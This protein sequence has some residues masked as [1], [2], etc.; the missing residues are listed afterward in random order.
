MIST[1]LIEASAGTG[2][3]YTMASL[4]IR[5]LLQAGENHFSRPLTVEEILV[6]TFT[7]AATQE[8]KE[9]IR[10][11]IR[12]SK[13]QL[14]S[15]LETH[16]KQVFVDN[17]F[18]A[19]LV[20][21]LPD[22]NIAIQRLRLA[23]Q[24]MD[25]AAIYTI[26]G[27]CRRVLMQYAFHSG[28]HF[29]MDLVKDETLL[30]QGFVQEFWR[31]QFYSAPFAVA[32]FIH[33]RFQSPKN[34]LKMI[35]AYVSGDNL[36]VQGS[37]PPSLTQIFQQ[38]E[39][40][41]ARIRQ[42][43]ATWQESAVEIQQV[44]EKALKNKQL[45][46]ASFRSNHLTAR[47]DKINQWAARADQLELPDVLTTYFSQQRLNSE[48]LLENAEP[49]EHAIF[50]Q[51][52]ELQNSDDHYLQ[53]SILYHYMQGVNQKLTA[54]KL[55]HREKSFDDLLRLL[56][57]ALLSAQ[58]DD[59]AQRLRQQY[60]FAMIDEFQDTDNRQYQIFA[61]IYLKQENCGFIMIGDPKQAI[62]KFRGADIFTYLHAAQQAER[63][64]LDK[65]YRSSAP[66]IE[67]ANQF[68]DFPKSP[69]L[70]DEIAFQPVGVGRSQAQ[71][72]FNNQAQAP[73]Q[74]YLGD[75]LKAAQSESKQLFADTCAYSI[76]QWLG[77]ADSKTTESKTAV[78][79]NAEK[80]TALFVKGEHSE[81][82]KANDIA[83]L[84]ENWYEA[85]LV[86]DSLRKQ[87][88]AS[89]YLSDRSNVFESDE[90]KELARILA[91]CLNPSNTKAIL[92][93]IATSLFAL[94]S[95]D[96]QQIKREDSLLEQWVNRFERY[97]RSW[98]HQGV[99]AMLYSLFLE[100]TDGKCSMVEKVRATPTGERRLTNLL[101]LAE[102]LQQ[103]SPL[104]ETEASLLRW[105]ELQIQH[106]Q[107]G[108]DEQQLR[109]ES[110]NQL[111]KIVT[112]HK[113]KGL[114]YGLVWLPFIAF[115]SL[116]KAKNIN[117]YHDENHQE[118]WDIRQQQQALSDKESM[119]EK[120]RLLY[121]ALTRAK[122]Q[123]NVA[124]PTVLA[125]EWTAIWYAL[126]QGKIGTNPK[127]KESDDTAQLLAQFQNALTSAEI[128][129]QLIS[130]L[131]L[132]QITQK[133]PATT[134]KT[135]LQAAVFTGDIELNWQL[136]SFTGLIQ[137]H[138]QHQKQNR[139]K[140]AVENSTVLDLAKDNDQF[141]PMA[142][143][144]NSEKNVV[145]QWQNYP[146]N[147]SPVD[148]PQGAKV[149]T[150][151]HSVLEKMNFN[152]PVNQDV[153]E[154]ICQQNQL[155]ESWFEPVAQWFD[156]ILH[157]PLLTDTPLCFADLAPQN[158]LKEMQFYFNL[159]RSFK[160]D[161]FNQI[162]QQH[163]HLAGEALLFDDVQG[164]MRGFIDLVFRHQG[165]YYIVDY[166][167]NFLGKLPQDYQ[168]EQLVKAMKTHHYD[169]QYLLYTLALNR[170]LKQRDPQYQYESHFG[171]VIY[172]FLRGMQGC[173]ASNE[174]VSGV[175][176]DRPEALLIEKLEA[177]FNA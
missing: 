36:K 21:Y 60:P 24:N 7:E 114:E 41:V 148:F 153:I 127:V 43:K 77:G 140:S 49:V 159:H 30:L 93:A 165:K 158:C 176:F 20:D 45:K 74:F 90:A 174:N 112:I 108:A 46:A 55:T 113:S 8:L 53:N 104:N 142:L 67:V 167:S 79:K 56:R 86:Q 128:N 115:S 70:Y 1:T 166:K 98:F 9:R 19:E 33:H 137:T 28:I 54:Y 152:Q 13:Q 15:Y 39:D 5:L 6:V 57:D 66:L 25:L 163:H 35:R 78:Q 48:Y 22:L 29:E 156:A 92:N 164:M 168:Q 136:S 150:L 100:K 95:A 146:E 125:K 117:T 149:G 97:Q 131:N 109:L 26:H 63:F 96:I 89:V 111:V 47:F 99:L 162:L 52:D 129:T 88:I 175:F 141:L 31:E 18:L 145:T 34:V 135:A 82:V 73:I 11:R 160:V 10:Q 147:R 94:S 122:Y 84:V 106:Q 87:G 120:M 71:F 101:H 2:K 139:L 32:Q 170:Y 62:Y 65:N 177:L 107:D 68:F 81:A 133:S 103:A 91:A 27:F 105:F 58:G 151:L 83:V 17:P 155:D 144:D 59:F 4:Y 126:S 138:L 72:Y 51:V 16:D 12:L 124:L 118:F 102:L 119:A 40:N 3:T 172:T 44:F 157:T 154:R 121:V 50:A 61:K 169:V 123:L 37:I 14:E 110:E 173:E 75:N 132:E 85:K 116:G 64:T 69:F 42:F 143:T 134:E 130:E 171:G 38:I 161:E 80:N 23:E 76:A